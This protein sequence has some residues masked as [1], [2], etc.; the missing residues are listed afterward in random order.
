MSVRTPSRV[1]VFSWATRVSLELPVGFVQ[2][3]EA[4]EINAAV[5]AD[6]LDAD[7]PLG[8]RILVKAVPVPPGDEEAAGDLADVSAELPGRALE[9]RREIEVDGR[10]AVLQLLRYRQED[11]DVEVVRLEAYVP[12]GATVFSLTGLAPTHAADRYVPVF[13][14]AFSTA[15]LVLV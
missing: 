4:P 9:W 3:D 12:T 6:D 13:E 15:R 7:A 1:H 10:D 5:Y 14:Q 2:A 8:G 11:L